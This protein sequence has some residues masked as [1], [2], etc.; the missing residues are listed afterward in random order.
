MLRRARDDIRGD[1]VRTNSAVAGASGALQTARADSYNPGMGSSAGNALAGCALAVAG[2]FALAA[3]SSAA[4]VWEYAKFRDSETGSDRH[5]V[6]T[7]IEYD[8]AVA[9]LAFVCARG[10]LV[11]TVVATWPIAA[12]L[13]YRFP[14]EAAQWM[15]GNTPVPSSAVFQGEEVR[16]LFDT[17]L[18]RRE[19]MIRI[20]GPRTITEKTLELRDFAEKAQPLTEACGEK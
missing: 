9:A 4:T 2:A 14:P 10:R 6:Q 16:K 20:P 8:G 12:V 15:G 19:L 11:L 18:V 13:R 5:T 3:P 1:S 17:A 7:K